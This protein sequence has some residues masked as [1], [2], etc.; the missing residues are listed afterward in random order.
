MGEQ[1]LFPGSPDGRPAVDLGV[2]E[3]FPDV[4]SGRHLACQSH[5]Q[6]LHRG[7]RRRIYAIDA[8]TGKEVK[9]FEKASRESVALSPDGGTVY[10]KSM[11]H[12]VWAIDTQTLDVRWTS[13]TGAG[14]DISPTPML[15]LPDVGVIM[16][17]DKGNLVCFRDG[18]PAW[19]YKVSV[20][21]VNPMEG[22][23]DER[24]GA[25]F[26]LASTMDGV[27]ELLTIH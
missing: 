25:A 12:S 23:K 10:G 2:H 26:L 24:K 17:T 16:P 21:L 9:Y 4:F 7:P 1:T 27:I 8:A 22:W 13:E 3:T 6:D 14:Y 20:A 18:K 19:A 11:Y 5:R 15:Q